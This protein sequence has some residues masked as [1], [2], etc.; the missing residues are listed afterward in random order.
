MIKFGTANIEYTDIYKY[1]G[2]D[3]IEHLSLVQFIEKTS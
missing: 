2:V 3:F 1:L